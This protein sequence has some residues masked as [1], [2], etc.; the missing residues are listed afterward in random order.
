MQWWSQHEFSLILAK[1]PIFGKCCL[2]TIFF[3][4]TSY[5]VTE[6]ILFWR[7]RGRK[8]GRNKGEEREEGAGERERQGGRDCLLCP[9]YRLR[10]WGSKQL[11]AQDKW[12]STHKHTL[13]LGPCGLSYLSFKSDVLRNTLTC[14]NIWFWEK[15]NQY[16]FERYSLKANLIIY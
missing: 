1:Y 11:I 3:L 13:N 6:G 12:W 15:K 5:A 2:F 10:S 8:G 14:T 9:F 7:E 4:S 16:S